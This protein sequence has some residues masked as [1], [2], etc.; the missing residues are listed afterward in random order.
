MLVF[1]AFHD[2]VGTFNFDPHPDD[3]FFT[4]FLL[5][6]GAVE[7]RD[8]IERALG[9]E[10]PGTLIFDYPT[11]SAISAFAV[12]LMTSRPAEQVWELLDGIKWYV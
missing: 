4:I 8:G 5:E 6:T 3:G 1:N 10:L 7:V 12:A 11:V 9:L 2:V